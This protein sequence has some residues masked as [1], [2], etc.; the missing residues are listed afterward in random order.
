MGE[1]TLQQTRNERPGGLQPAGLNPPRE[2]KPTRRGRKPKQETIHLTQL[3]YENREFTFASE[4]PVTVTNKDG[5]WIFE[6]KE[7]EI[8]GFDESKEEAFYAFRMDFDAR[9]EYIASEDDCKL[10]KNARQLKKQLKSL[11]AGIRH[12]E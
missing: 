2:A 5:V 4:M 6:S 10:T 8:I 7:F 3:V 9:W 12:I 1:A 11:V